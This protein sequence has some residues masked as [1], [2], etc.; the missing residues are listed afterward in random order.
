MLSLI[1]S[2]GYILSGSL[3]GLNEDGSNEVYVYKIPNPT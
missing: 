3:S 1:T 2:R